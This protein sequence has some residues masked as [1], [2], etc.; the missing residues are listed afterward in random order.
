MKKFLS[1]LL[2]LTLV[3]A[4]VACSN[5]KDTSSDIDTSTTTQTETESSDQTD[6]T[7]NDT[8]S[9]ES[10]TNESSSDTETPSN[11][12]PTSTETSKPTTSSKDNTTSSKPS[13][14]TSTP[15]TSK[16][17]PTEKSELLFKVNDTAFEIGSFEML[18]ESNEIKNIVDY[19]FYLSLFIT[20]DGKLYK[21]GNFSDGT[22]LRQIAKDSG[23]NFVKFSRGT[24]ISS[25]N[26]VYMYE[27]D[28]FDVKL[29]NGGMGYTLNTI[30]DTKDFIRSGHFFERDTECIHT[31]TVKDNEIYIHCDNVI[32][33]STPNFIFSDDEVIELILDGTIKT[34]KGY[35]L[36]GEKFI[37]SQY[38]D[39]PSKY[40]QTITKAT[41][42]NSDVIFLKNYKSVSSSNTMRCFAN[43][44]GQL[45]VWK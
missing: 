28:K 42:L 27:E 43:K 29:F 9:S 3:F 4:F 23:I 33:S 6:T 19:N 31:Y 5:E 13:N 14:T 17:T 2:T 30:I 24:V 40:E 41:D 34:N 16:P 7:D 44:K 38:D 32:N 18:I 12:T 10:D 26:D 35:Y 39:I 15:T 1:L 25:N 20:K 21:I 37:P 8:K 11:S 22:K 45:F 36:F